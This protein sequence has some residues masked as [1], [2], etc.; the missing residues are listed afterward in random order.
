MS[1][2][3]FRL[4]KALGYGCL[5]WV[6]SFVW[7]SIIFMMPQTRSLSAIPY[8]ARN[9][10]LSFPLLVIWPALTWLLSKSYLRGAG[11][12]VV[13]GVKLGRLFLIVNLILNHLVLVMLLKNGANFYLSLSLWLAYL[14]LLIAPWLAGRALQ[15]EEKDRLRARA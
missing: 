9:P 3:P 11:D 14:S 7:G 13:E 5:L 15:T 8:I 10:A 4:G 6:T 2:L 12:K 1:F